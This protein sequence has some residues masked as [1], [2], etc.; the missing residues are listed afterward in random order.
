M[1]IHGDAESSHFTKC[2]RRA[3]ASP[4]RHIGMI[5]IRR[6]KL[7][8]MFASCLVHRFASEFELTCAATLIYVPLA[9]RSNEPSPV[10]AAQTPRHGAD[11]QE[12]H[13][14]V[15]T[16]AALSTSGFAS[17]RLLRRRRVTRYAACWWPSPTFRPSRGG[18]RPFSCHRHCFHFSWS[19]SL[20]LPL[21]ATSGLRL[22]SGP[23]S[24]LASPRRWRLWELFSRQQG[25]DGTQSTVC[26][27]S[28]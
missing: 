25:T 5:N 12:A 27:A 19:A 1:A 13:R 23:C 15:W 26:T 7:I 16:P 2:N 24:T 3:P 6:R 8:S 10:L 17:G 28:L 22:W 20:P 14:Y 11:A 21:I 9:A 18:R 4:I